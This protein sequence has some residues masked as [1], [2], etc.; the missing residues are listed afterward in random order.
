MSDDV[1]DFAKTDPEMVDLWRGVSCSHLSP[2]DCVLILPITDSAQPRKALN[3]RVSR[4]ISQVL[5]ATLP[6]RKHTLSLASIRSLHVHTDL[7]TF[8]VV[9]GQSV[10]LFP[11][12]VKS[13]N[14][15]RNG[16]LNGWRRLPLMEVLSCLDLHYN[17]GGQAF[18]FDFVYIW[19]RKYIKN[20]H[21]CEVS[22]ER[23][24]ASSS[25]L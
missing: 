16:V 15:V 23:Q 17:G 1:G 22:L 20:R 25:D 10:S 6:R 5:S 7:L 24:P 14:W 21:V 2:R 13:L 9:P 4:R 3:M 8:R 11:F 18:H 19:C 12:S